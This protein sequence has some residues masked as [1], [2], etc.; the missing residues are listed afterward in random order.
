MDYERV[1]SLLA[2]L[3]MLKYFP[4][5]ED[6]LIA[7]A[8]MIGRMATS[9]DQVKW[10]VGRTLDLH[11]E[12]PGPLELRAIFCSRWRPAD[13]KEAYSAIYIGGIPPEKP[14]IPA[15]PSPA[16]PAL[17]PGHVASFDDEADEMIRQLSEACDM[18]RST[19]PRLPFGKASPTEPPRE[20][21][22]TAPNPNFKPITEADIQRAVEDMRNKRALAELHG[23]SS[24]D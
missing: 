6:A 16:L 21:L 8:K 18:N 14:S 13:R 11:N 7:V 3:A 5:G 20:P 2:D 9:E 23:E 1:L 4:S 10:L 22:N 17:P 19:R 15:L 12:W 24:T